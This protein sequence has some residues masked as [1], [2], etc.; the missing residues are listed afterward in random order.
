MSTIEGLKKTHGQSFRQLAGSTDRSS[1][2]KQSEFKTPR[3][4]VNTTE[5][6]MMNL[7]EK[8]GF[9]LLDSELKK[10]VEG[11]KRQSQ[12]KLAGTRSFLVK[13][14]NSLSRQ[15]T[16]QT[17]Y[18]EMM[19]RPKKSVANTA[20]ERSLAP[21][22]QFDSKAVSF[23]SSVKDPAVFQAVD[24]SLEQIIESTIQQADIPTFL[25]NKGELLTLLLSY[26]ESFARNDSSQMS[27]DNLALTIE[28]FKRKL[29]FFDRAHTSMLEKFAGDFSKL[30]PRRT[31]SD[32]HKS[33]EGVLSSSIHLD[34]RYLSAAI[35]GLH[36]FYKKKM[37]MFRSKDDKLADAVTALNDQYM[38]AKATLQIKCNNRSFKKMIETLDFMMEEW[39]KLVADFGVEKKKCELETEKHAAVISELQGSIESSKKLIAD[40]HAQLRQ[41]IGPDIKQIRTE[42]E[43]NF[44][45]VMNN[46]KEDAEKA[47]IERDEAVKKA[48]ELKTALEKFEK[49]KLKREANTQNKA[50][51]AIFQLGAVKESTQPLTDTLKSLE[52]AVS[53]GDSG[54]KAWLCSMINLIIVRRLNFELES[55]NKHLPPKPMKDFIIE[56]LLIKFGSSQTTQH[57]LRDIIASLRKFGSEGDRFKLFAKFMGVEDVLNSEI[58]RRRKGNKYEEYLS[59]YYYTSHLAVR[60]YLEFCLLVKGFEFHEENTVKP[61]I[62]FSLNPRGQL[63][64]V[65]VAKK[66]YVLFILNQENKHHLD[67][68]VL[69]EDFENYLKEDLYD[70]LHEKGKEIRVRNFKN[71]EFFISYDYLAR[72]LVER[73]LALFINYMQRFLSALTIN[74]AAR[75]EKHIFFDDLVYSCKEILPHIS[76]Y[77]IGHIFRELLDTPQMQSYSIE[78][79]I[80]STVHTIVLLRE[81]SHKADLRWLVIPRETFDD[82]NAI[83]GEAEERTEGKIK[84]SLCKKEGS[85]YLALIDGMSVWRDKQLAG[86][87]EDPQRTDIQALTDL[88]KTD[89]MSSLAA[90]QECYEK[91]HSLVSVVEK[92]D[93][94]VQLLNQDLKGFLSGIPEKV[95]SRSTYEDLKDQDTWELTSQ[96]EALWKKLRRIITIAFYHTS[97]S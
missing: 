8:S 41:Q 74:S 40:L 62:G 19:L 92:T 94:T 81:Q 93:E 38:D 46:L 36:S 29:E 78:R 80:L 75:G 60:D 1:L 69:E 63:I 53:M 32:V 70:R 47:F 31:D 16:G 86:R 4:F 3:D 72:I 27:K 43:N 90:L 37:Q 87:L 95:V 77:S 54:S 5:T 59:N 34:V 85:R 13:N 58:G 18:I 48:V 7:K 56:T 61:F 84:R 17:K 76:E 2:F 25:E 14:S 12:K 55:S 64:K 30:L 20:N 10:S 33:E 24:D 50:V 22:I 52:I 49:E 97:S 23:Y 15:V 71:E 11:L 57:I 28:I 51:Q 21:Q 9:E 66:V 39:V 91:I 83:H 82:R 96:L 73:R 89:N 26:V 65:D 35:S 6:I 88:W 67:P 42:C 68:E 79:M 44:V 45:H